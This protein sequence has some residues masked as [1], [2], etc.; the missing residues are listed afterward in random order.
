MGTIQL[1]SH[2]EGPEY[3]KGPSMDFKL[4]VQGPE[5]DKTKRPV[6]TPGA[7]S[8]TTASVTEVIPTST[9]IA[10]VEM[11]TPQ[12]LNTNPSN[13]GTTME[14]TTDSGADLTLEEFAKDM[15]KW[16]QEVDAKLDNNT[17]WQKQ[18][19]QKLK[20]LLEFRF[21][22]TPMTWSEARYHCVK[23]GGRLAFADNELERSRIRGY[24]VW[25]DLSYSGSGCIG[26]K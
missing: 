9:K 3:F 10:T 1:E 25:I 5:N 2:I 6:L 21:I 24:D 7:T 16:Q 4:V 8:S 12:T 19:D 11:T 17:E 22:S 14:T 26:L 15:T 20:F 13:V 18:V 23:L